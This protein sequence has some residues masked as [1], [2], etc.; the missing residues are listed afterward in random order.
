M[1]VMIRQSRPDRPSSRKARS[2][3]SGPAEIQVPTVSRSPP[4]GAASGSAEKNASAATRQE[5]AMAPAAT[6]TTVSRDHL[7]PNN[8]RI[9][10][11][12]N[13]S[14][15]MRR[16]LKVT[17][18]SPSALHQGDFVEVDRLTATEEADQDRQPH[19]RLGGRQ[20]DD[21]EGEHVPLHVA[22]LAGKGQ[23]GQVAAVELQLDRHE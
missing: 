1:K 7:R 21:Q 16:R 10:A 8:I 3:F 9:A 22:E 19:R 11:P 4:L 14:S 12:R 17:T 23:Q 20:G 18:A 13:G 6:A 15:G 2:I 5:P